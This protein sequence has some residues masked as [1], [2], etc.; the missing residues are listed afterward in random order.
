MSQHE[1]CMIDV[2]FA[3]PFYIRIPWVTLQQHVRH[4]S[5]Y[6]CVPV[7]QFSLSN[8]AQTAGKK[9]RS[10]RVSFSSL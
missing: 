5:G 7:R 4:L 6:I 1:G 10:Q 8:A 9:S 2:G 3:Y